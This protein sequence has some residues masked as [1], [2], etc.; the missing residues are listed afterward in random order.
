M[1]GNRK[2]E[3]RNNRQSFVILQG[4]LQNL[5]CPLKKGVERKGRG[6]VEEDEKKE[7]GK[8]MCKK[9]LY[10]KKRIWKTGEERKGRGVVKKQQNYV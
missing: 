3:N 9:L 5:L 10:I 6:V 4:I 7:N 1:L 8:I 2:R